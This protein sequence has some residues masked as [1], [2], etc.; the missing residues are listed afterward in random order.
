LID[1]LIITVEFSVELISFE[2]YE[3][4]CV[5]IVS[6]KLVNLQYSTVVVILLH[7]MTNRY[8]VL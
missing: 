1:S 2:H 4:K 6:C 8:C 5:N 3:L 7:C